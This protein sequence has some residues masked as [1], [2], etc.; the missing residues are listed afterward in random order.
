MLGIF[1]D[2]FEK[3]L[4]E[5]GRFLNSFGLLLEPFLTIFMK[6]ITIIKHKIAKI[7]VEN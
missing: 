7:I 1:H 5:S 6:Y 4:Q 3:C 2:F